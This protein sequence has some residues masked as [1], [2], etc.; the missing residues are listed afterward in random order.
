MS[1][2]MPLTS[3]TKLKMVFDSLKSQKKLDSGAV[4]HRC[5][6][7][8]ESGLGPATSFLI[9]GHSLNL[10]VSSLLVLSMG[11]IKKNYTAIQ[12]TIM[13]SFTLEFLFS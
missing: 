8:G 2:S 4:S 6:L 11:S 13:E 5:R 7:L 10:P 1:Q 3:V 12:W 9:L